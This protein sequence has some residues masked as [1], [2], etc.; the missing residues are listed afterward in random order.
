MSAF[1]RLG[2]LSTSVLQVSSTIELHVFYTLSR[3]SLRVTVSPTIDLFI[4]P[5]LLWCPNE[6][7]KSIILKPVFSFPHRVL[8]IINLLENDV[9]VFQ[10]AN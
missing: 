10:K 2:I 7:C 5:Q 9:Q 8:R 4:A 1:I 3:Y 6:R